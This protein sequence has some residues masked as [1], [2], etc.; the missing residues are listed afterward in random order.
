M[1][2]VKKKFFTS[3]SLMSIFGEYTNT[4]F[5]YLQNKKPYS[6]GRKGMNFG[7]SEI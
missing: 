4:Y 3:E 5:T 1:T 2:K 6:S 7:V